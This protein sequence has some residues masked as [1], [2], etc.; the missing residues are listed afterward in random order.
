[1]SISRALTALAA[2]VILLSPGTASAAAPGPVDQAPVAA[3]TFVS[4]DPAVAATTVLHAPQP[5]SFAEPPTPAPLNVAGQ[6]PCMYGSRK[7]GMYFAAER[8]P[9][10]INGVAGYVPYVRD[11]Y[12]CTGS[13]GIWPSSSL[14]NGANLQGSGGSPVQ[15]GYGKKDGGSLGFWYTPQ[16]SCGGC[17]TT[18]PSASTFVNGHVE[19]P[20]GG[21]EKSPPPAVSQAFANG[22]PALVLASLIR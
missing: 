16:D 20:A 15:V 19:V 9:S 17:Y 11:L 7:N 5:N 6:N 18:W 13:L 12:P 2:L 8:T 14:V 21:H 3:K 1:M 22:P 10:N 4:P